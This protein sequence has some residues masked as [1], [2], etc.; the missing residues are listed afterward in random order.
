MSVSSIISSTHPTSLG[1]RM[2]HLAIQAASSQRA[3]STDRLSVKPAQFLQAVV[4]SLAR[5]VVYSVLRRKCTSTGGS[6]SH[7]IVAC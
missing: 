6:P 5:Q 7:R 3:S 4:I 2:S 1:K